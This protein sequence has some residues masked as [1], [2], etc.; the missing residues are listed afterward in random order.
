L[1]VLA[2]HARV[3][4]IHGGYLGVDLFFVL[5]GFLITTLVAKEIKAGS[6]SFSGFYWRRAWR[7]LPAAYATL[8][9]CVAIA[10][11]L[12]TNREM[13]EFVAQVWGAVTFTANFVLWQQTGYFER[14]A[15]LKPLLHVWSLSIEEQYYFVLPALLFFLR[16]SKWLAAAVLMT[17]C[18]FVLCIFVTYESPAAAFYWL[19]TRAW[20]MGLGSVAAVLAP[21]LHGLSFR[22]KQHVGLLG[23]LAI[24]GIAL[25]PL[26]KV[27]PGVDAL[28]ACVATVGIVLLP[29][30]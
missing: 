5:S 30:V 8:A 4:L 9:L 2:H 26:S 19:P 3:P 25:F 16:P 23:L 15:E 29:T 11:F 22:G 13:R 28:I 18:S 17:V 6:F 21:R 7:L 27:H 24:A 12:V 10:P 14:A 1:L 20:E